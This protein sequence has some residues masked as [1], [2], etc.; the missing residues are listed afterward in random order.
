M[1]KLVNAFLK[2]H[3][4]ELGLKGYTK[5]T[6][7]EKLDYLKS[8]TKGT[9]YE[10]EISKFTKPRVD[11]GIKKVLDKSG[12]GKNVRVKK[13]KKEPYK[14]TKE[15]KS[16][17]SKSNKEPKKEEPK[18]EEPKQEP[19]K[20]MPNDFSSVKTPED[21]TKSAKIKKQIKSIVGSNNTLK[22]PSKERKAITNKAL[23]N[24]GFSKVYEVKEEIKNYESLPQNIKDNLALYIYAVPRDE[25]VPTPTF[26]GDKFS[27]PRSYGSKG[28]YEYF[29]NA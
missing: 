1:L 15:M 17:H 12:R 9:K 3:R 25:V 4:K 23:L 16:L 14:F 29:Y 8:K 13:T 21:I 24:V 27:S 28:A 11:E 19:K 7:L 18:K 20:K 10:K 5:M 2:Q 26:K 22:L 6:Y